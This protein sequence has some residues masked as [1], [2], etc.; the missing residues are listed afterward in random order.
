MNFENAV[1]C[2]P[3]GHEYH[4]D[5]LFI[6]S[7]NIRYVHVPETVSVIHIY[8]KYIL[9]GKKTVIMYSIIS[10]LDINFISNKK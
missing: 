7:R 5:N 6:Q 4:F 10:F 2:D 1:Y 9:Y 3:Q 8:N